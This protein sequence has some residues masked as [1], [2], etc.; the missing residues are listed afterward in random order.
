MPTRSARRAASS[1]GGRARTPA[2][3]AAARTNGAKGGRQREK[4]PE[5]LLKELGNPPG[6]PL[7][8]A[9]WWGRLLEV[10]QIGVLK[11]RPWIQLMRDARANAAIAAK[12]LPDEIKA[13]ALQLLEQDEQD[14]REDASA[15]ETPREADPVTRHGSRALRRDPARA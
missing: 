1:K 11:G 4:L 12:L 15:V 9:A 2:K 7:K 6:D 8:K 5:Q 3:R 10:V 13:K 14:K